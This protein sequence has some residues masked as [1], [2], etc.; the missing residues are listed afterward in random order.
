M[1]RPLPDPGSTLTPQ[2]LTGEHEV[3][4]KT[5]TDPESTIESQLITGKVTV[6]VETSPRSGIHTHTT[7]PL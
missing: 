7:A 6:S 4:V 2:L 5:P 1:L 3:T